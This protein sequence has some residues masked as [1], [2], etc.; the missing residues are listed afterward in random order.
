M[1][2]RGRKRK[3]GARTD[4]GRLSRAAPRHDRGNAR[5][6]RMQELYG[7][8]GSDAI[9]RAFGRGLLGTDADAKAMLDTARSIHRAYWSHYAVGTP[10][11]TLADRN[12]GAGRPDNPERDRAIEHALNAKLALAGRPGSNERSAFDQLVIDINPDSGPTWLDRVL[13]KAAQ[14]NDWGRLTAALDALADC[15]AVARPTG[16][17]TKRLTQA[18]K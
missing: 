16:D 9:G 14:A 4:S 1:A 12:S 17:I 8:N 10:R 18:A 5:A 13:G 2:K 11:C 15:A 7:T 3:T 6:E